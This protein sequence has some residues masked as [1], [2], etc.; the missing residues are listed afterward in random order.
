MFQEYVTRILRHKF[1]GLGGYLGKIW[2]N[3]RIQNTKLQKVAILP[4]H[5]A[6][7]WLTI[8][9]RILDDPHP[10][11]SAEFCDLFLGDG[12]FT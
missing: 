4:G 12:E 2:K 5:S 1:W 6:W 11:N 8:P 9:K 3:P 7:S 10:G